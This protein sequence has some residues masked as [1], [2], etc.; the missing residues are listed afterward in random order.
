MSLGHWARPSGWV[1][2][3]IGPRPQQGGRP[4]IR[5]GVQKLRKQRFVL[6]GSALYRFFVSHATPDALAPKRRY[7]I[8]LCLLSQPGLSAR[9]PPLIIRAPWAPG[10]EIESW[11]FC[12][13]VTRGEL[14]SVKRPAGGKVLNWV[15]RICTP[16]EKANTY[17]CLMM[18]RN[19]RPKSFL[20][21]FITFSW[22][23]V[24][25][26][27]SQN[28]QTFL[29]HQSRKFELIKAILV[30]G[31]VNINTGIASNKKFCSSHRKMAIIQ[32]IITLSRKKE[33]V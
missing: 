22:H 7:Y 33:N 30:F 16:L 6:K 21:I 13:V 9:P 4:P 29:L 23:F 32:L 17:I 11:T 18:G 15:N 19:S 12:F 28:Q 25:M 3:I 14:E 5:N 24:W 20:C 26:W 8:S 10:N 31:W 27:C 1:A 2:E